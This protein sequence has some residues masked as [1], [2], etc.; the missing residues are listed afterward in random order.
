VFD[1]WRPLS[2]RE[3][4]D[5]DKY[6]GPHEGVPDWMF[7]PLWGWVDEHLPSVFYRGSLYPPGVATYRSMAAALRTRF[8]DRDD[9]DGRRIEK[10]LYDYVSYDSGRLLDVAEWVLGNR[11]SGDIAGYEATQTLNGVL[12]TAGSIYEVREDEGG[13]FYLSRRVTE[14]MK[15]SAEDA[16]RPADKATSHLAAAWRAVYGRNPNPGHGYVQAVKAIE[17]VAI[18]VVSPKNGSATLGSVIRDMRASPANW[19]IELHH[20]NREDQTLAFVQ[21][22]DLIWKGQLRHG[23]PRPDVPLDVTLPEAEATLHLAIPIVK[24]FRD[25]TVRRA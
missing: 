24:W 14:E 15:A 13:K 21:A 19:R 9:R 10:G 4:G 23:D 1:R 7:A 6:D 5:K 12:A 25:G 22:L 17:V 2:V 11:L 8:E 18:P 3:G 20:P 16:M